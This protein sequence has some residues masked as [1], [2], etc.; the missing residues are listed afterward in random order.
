MA[1]SP[2]SPR[3]L[4]EAL[5]AL[6]W[7]RLLCLLPMRWWMRLAGLKRADTL[8][9]ED[10]EEGP[11]VA[12]VQRHIA[13]LARRVLWRADCLP[14]AL[15]TMAMLSRRGYRPLLHLGARRLANAAAPTSGMRAHAWVVCGQRVVSGAPMHREYLSV[16]C[17]TRQRGEKSG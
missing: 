1:A 5:S 16:A 9:A 13:G 3:L 6:L 14:Q 7:A 8:Q 10:L 15:A 12:R 4:A 11:E 17:L 2:I